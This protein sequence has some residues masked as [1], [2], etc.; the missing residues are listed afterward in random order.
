MCENAWEATLE[1]YSLVAGHVKKLELAKSM[2][3]YDTEILQ[4]LLSGDRDLQFQVLLA[5]L[6]I[7]NYKKVSSV[8]E[9]QS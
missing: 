1:N 3:L 4:A 6:S 7:D 2:G 5:K 9:T 8:V